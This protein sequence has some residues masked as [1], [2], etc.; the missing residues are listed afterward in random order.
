MPRARKYTPEEAYQR[1]LESN[2]RYQ[3]KHKEVIY[4]NQLK[5]KAKN[6]ITKKATRDELLYFQDLITDKLHEKE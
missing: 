4:R 3:D 1:K 6:F 5:S 2:K